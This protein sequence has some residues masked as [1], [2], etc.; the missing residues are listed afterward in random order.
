MPVPITFRTNGAWGA[1]QG[2]D[3]SAAQVDGNFYELK[4]AVEDLQADAPGDPVSISNIV[5]T[6]N[7]ITIYLTDSTALG[8]FTLPSAS[9]FNPPQEITTDT[10]TLALADRTKYLWCTNAAGCLVTIPADDEVA[11]PVGFEYHFEQAAAAPVLFEAGSGVVLDYD[12]TRNPATAGQYCVVTLK[13]KAADRWTR[14]G[15][16]E[17]GT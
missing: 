12:A 15:A 7:S 6:G 5:Q 9:V 11:I 17:D 1:G 14:F 16:P 4:Q 3:L 8:P 13:K 2:S 10:Y